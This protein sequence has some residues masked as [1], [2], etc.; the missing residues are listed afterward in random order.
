MK[1]RKENNQ[2]TL[3]FGDIPSIPTLIRMWGGSPTSNFPR[4]TFK[5]VKRFVKCKVPATS[6]FVHAN[7]EAGLLTRNAKPK[8]RYLVGNSTYRI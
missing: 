4:L 5:I 7:V 6:H 8:T 2:K 3:I 1:L